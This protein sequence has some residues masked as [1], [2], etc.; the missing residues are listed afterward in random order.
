MFALLQRRSDQLPF[1]ISFEVIDKGPGGVLVVVSKRFYVINISDVAY[2]VEVEEE[3][4][5]GV[6]LLKKR[7]RSVFQGHL[8]DAGFSGGVV[9]VAQFVHRLDR[10]GI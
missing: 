7:S 5:R 8:P 9:R 2:P 4:A 6:V 10:F 1:F 3:A